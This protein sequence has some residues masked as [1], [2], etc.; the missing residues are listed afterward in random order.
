M[1]VRLWWGWHEQNIY[2]RFNPRTREGAT[3]DN[4]YYI[5]DTKVSIHAPVKVRHSLGAW[6]LNVLSVSI[7]APVKVR[8]RMKW[9]TQ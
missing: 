2:I 1:K 7:H 4:V 3:G 6:W 9:Q 8:L 5:G